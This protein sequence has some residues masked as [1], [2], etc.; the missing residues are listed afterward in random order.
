MKSW[1]VDSEKLGY[2]SETTLKNGQIAM[3]FFGRCNP[4]VRNDVY[5]IAFAIADKK[6]EITNWINSKEDKFNTSM[7]GRDGI[8]GLIWAKQQIILFE[9]YLKNDRFPTPVILEVSWLDKKRKEI[10]KRALCR[11][12]FQYGMRDHQMVLFKKLNQP[13]S[14]T[15]KRKLK[16]VGKLIEKS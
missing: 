16:K 7:T 15:E 1:Y 6:K 10:Y 14:K 9:S 4:D 12:G 11:L 5:N 2:F 13:L 8:E 3:M